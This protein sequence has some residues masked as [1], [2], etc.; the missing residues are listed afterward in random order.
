[1]PRRRKRTESL[2]GKDTYHVLHDGT[3]LAVRGPAGPETPGALA[4]VI[5]Q[6]RA[7][8]WGA[9]VTLTVERRSL[10]GPATPIYRVVRDED[11]VVKSFT[12]TLE[13]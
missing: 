13:S 11:G 2:A 1:M 3:E 9:S 7:V 10:F 8:K 5:A 6:G 4:L 12:L